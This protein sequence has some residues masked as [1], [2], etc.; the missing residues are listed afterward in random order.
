MKKTLSILSLISVAAL[1]PTS[2]I[3]AQSSAKT[4]FEFFDI[5][6]GGCSSDTIGTPNNQITDISSDREVLPLHHYKS[7]KKQ[8]ITLGSSYAFPNGH[9]VFEENKLWGLRNQLGQIIIKPQWDYVIIDYKYHGIIGYSGATCSYYSSEGEPILAKNTYYHIQPTEPKTY[10]I[11]T[12]SGYGIVQKEKVIFEPKY[13]LIEYIAPKQ[14]Y[15]VYK[16]RQDYKIHV[17]NFQASFNYKNIAYGFH[18]IDEET[19]LAGNIPINLK[20]KRQLLCNQGF[21]VGLVS[22]EHQLI[23]VRRHKSI[24]FDMALCNFQGDILYSS[25]YYSFSARMLGEDKC[26]I[27]HNKMN[28]ETKKIEPSIGV[29]NIKSKKWELDPVFNISTSLGNVMYKTSY[30]ED[31]SSKLL[32]K[33]YYD[34]DL[35]I[36]GKTF[37]HE[38]VNNGYELIINETDDSYCVLDSKKA[39]VILKGLT[40]DDYEYLKKQICQNRFIAPNWPST[41]ELLENKDYYLTDFPDNSAIKIAPKFYFSN[42]RLYTNESAHTINFCDFSEKIERIKS[43]KNGR[44]LLLESN[45]GSHTIFDISSKKQILLIPK[46]D[47]IISISPSNDG[48]LIEDSKNRFEDIIL[49]NGD[50]LFD[51]SAQY[52]TPFGFGLFQIYKRDLG[53]AVF[54]INNTMIIPWQKKGFGYLN[55]LIYSKSTKEYYDIKGNFVR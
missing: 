34:H 23:T 42:G 19:I 18:I 54:D 53:Y 20:S 37:G 24:G 30:L 4:I 50:Y 12:P 46:Q 33:E 28:P 10:I 44:H 35:K 1:L 21:R 25:D 16:S 5:P 31:S 45:Y 36:V 8:E 47:G 51:K 17:N 49:P 22:K 52:C 2:F 15:M 39:K 27:F 11:N 3:S 9:S 41:K 32:V 26:V 7:R 13:E 6:V 43:Q 29:I 14:A 48:F 40:N 55:G 38:L